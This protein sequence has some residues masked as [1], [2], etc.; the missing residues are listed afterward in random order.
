MSKTFGFKGVE[1]IMGRIDPG[2]EEATI[3]GISDGTNDNGKYYLAVKMKTIDGMREHEER[4]YFSTERGERISLQRLKS[5][6]SELVDKTKA[7]GEYSLEQLNALL[8]GKTGRWK[9]VGEE[10]EYNGDLRM[11]VQLDFSNFVEN[12]K[13][14]KAESKLKFDPKKD[15]KFLPDPANASQPA[16]PEVNF[17]YV[18]NAPEANAEEPLF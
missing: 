4:F 3:T 11:R 6:I 5:I 18:D 15:V 7:E 1:Q 14:P 2:I 13:V 16:V 17:D 8:S 12:I 10:Y 9:F